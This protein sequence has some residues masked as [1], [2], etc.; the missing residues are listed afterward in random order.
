[1]LSGGTGATPNN[2]LPP[3]RPGLVAPEG[4]WEAILLPP[5]PRPT[6]TAGGA[7]IAA[8]PTRAGAV[9][10]AAAAGRASPVPVDVTNNAAAHSEA[11]CSILQDVFL[12]GSLSNQT[13][14]RLPL[15]Q[16]RLRAAKA[17]RNA[18][19]NT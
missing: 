14:R 13:S 3:L 6:A 11:A 2:G 15:S 16:G 17:A 5:L 7:S 4:L 10:R 19:R 18:R 1:M 8:A 9:A 12:I